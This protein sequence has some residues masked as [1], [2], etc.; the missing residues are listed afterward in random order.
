MILTFPFLLVPYLT[1]RRTP[2][3]NP[4]SQPSLLWSHKPRL[5]AT[6]VSLT[7]ECQRPFQTDLLIHR[8]EVRTLEGQCRG[9]TRTT[10]AASYG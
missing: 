9:S 3:E 6:S 4:S 10:L 5:C 8:A 2:V 7:I 1:A